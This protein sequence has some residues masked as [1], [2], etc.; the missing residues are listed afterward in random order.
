MDLH[1][2]LNVT[3]SFSVTLAVDEND[4]LVPQENPAA[5]RLLEA[6]A[7]NVM[8]TITADGS[9]RDFIDRIEIAEVCTDSD[10]PIIRG[11]SG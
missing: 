2:R 6:V 10:Q 9:I 1:I 3:A 8:D 11:T 5:D 7:E 4:R